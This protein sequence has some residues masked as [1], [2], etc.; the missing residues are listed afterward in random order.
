[1]KQIVREIEKDFEIRGREKIDIVFIRW[2]NSNNIIDNCMIRLKVDGQIENLCVRE[3][4]KEINNNI[5]KWTL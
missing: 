1:M 4:P 5:S 3:R 2:D